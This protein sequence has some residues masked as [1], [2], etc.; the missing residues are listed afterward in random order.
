MS[1]Y[2]ASTAKMLCPDGKNYLMKVLIDASVF[3]QM[4]IERGDSRVQV[5]VKTRL[6]KFNSSL[7]RD[8]AR[9][10]VASQPNA[11]QPRWR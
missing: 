2:E 11:Q 8:H 5:R 9:G 10:A 3:P 4:L 6:S 1:A 7:K